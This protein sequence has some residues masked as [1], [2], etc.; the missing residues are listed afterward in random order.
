MLA[1]VMRLPNGFHHLAIQVRDLEGMARFYGEVL[2]LPVVRRW[3]GD[4]GE[5]SVW[6]G[7][8]AGF[9][10]LERAAGEPERRPF[11]DDRPGLHLVALSILPSDR[12]TWEARLSANGVPLEHRTDYSLYFFDPE[13]N[14]VALSH[15]PEAAP[16]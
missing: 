6:L 14:R 1:G 7:V 8:G 4:D 13:G 3:K 11:R 5:R 2:G 9:I 16:R 10:A 15:Y 12:L